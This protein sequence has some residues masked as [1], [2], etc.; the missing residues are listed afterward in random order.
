METISK[1]D[2]NTY[3]DC[4]LY[5]T[6]N[7]LSRQINKMADEAFIKTGLSPSYAFLMMVVCEEKAIGIGDLAK[8]LHLAPS[9]ITR[10]VDKLVAKK[11]LQR[12][13]SG[14]NMTINPTKKGEELLPLIHSCWKNLYE[15]YCEILGEEFAVKLT[16][17][18][19]KTN[20][21][22]EKN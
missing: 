16:S 3:L 19:A 10:F 20:K 2:T 12:E 9:T 7:S 21:T 18:M 22:L 8:A 15:E 5:F 11:Y 14:R 1:K 6:A 17:D 13:Q 4:C